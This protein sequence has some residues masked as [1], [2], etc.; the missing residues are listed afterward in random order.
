MKHTLANRFQARKFSIGEP[1]YDLLREYFYKNEKWFE[2]FEK[3]LF[4]DAKG[5]EEK[6]AVQKKLKVPTE[7]VTKAFYWAGQYGKI[8]EIL[9]VSEAEEEPEVPSLCLICGVE[10]PPDWSLCDECR[11]RE[12]QEEEEAM[13]Q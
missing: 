13:P 12:E 6:Y 3:E 5:L 8:K 11:L 4:K 9:G 2:D 1:P 7:P 10:I